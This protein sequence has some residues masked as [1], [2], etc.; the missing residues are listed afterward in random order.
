MPLAELLGHP[1]KISPGRIP[2]CLD[3]RVDNAGIACRLQRFLDLVWAEDVALAVGVELMRHG[4]GISSKHRSDRL[5]ATRVVPCGM[6]K[7]E[8]KRKDL[9]LR[10]LYA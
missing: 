2:V 4:V 9:A 1:A 7:R 6:V 3:H 8:L 10:A 5:G